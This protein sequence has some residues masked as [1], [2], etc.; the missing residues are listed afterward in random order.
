MM[1]LLLRILASW[2]P[3]AL[4]QTP[5]PTT[6]TTLATGSYGLVLAGLTADELTVEAAEFVSAFNDALKVSFSY[7]IRNVTAETSTSTYYYETDLVDIFL[8]AAFYAASATQA[9]VRANKFKNAVDLAVSVNENGTVPLENELSRC[10]D[11]MESALTN[12]YV[13]VSASADLLDAV[14]SF[15]F[16]TEVPTSAPTRMP[17]ISSLPTSVPTTPAPSSAL[18][19]SEPTSTFAPTGEIVRF[20]METGVVFESISS[21]Q[22]RVIDETVLIL[23]LVETVDIVENA[24]EVNVTS[25]DDLVSA[26]VD[27]LTPQRRLQSTT[28]NCVIKEDEATP[29]GGDEPLT[30]SNRSTGRRT[31]E[32]S[33]SLVVNFEVY[34]RA[35]GVDQAKAILAQFTKQLRA[36]VQTGDLETSIDS[37][38]NA[39]NK[40]TNISA[41]TVDV[42]SSVLYANCTEIRGFYYFPT[43]VP[44]IDISHASSD[45][46]ADISAN[47]H[48]NRRVNRRADSCSDPVSLVKS[49]A[50]SVSGPVNTPLYVSNVGTYIRPISVP[51]GGPVRASNGPSFAPSL[52]PSATSTVT[53][54]LPPI[55][56][57]ADAV[58]V[59]SSGFVLS[60]LGASDFGDE[61]EAIVQTAL[62]DVLGVVSDSSQIKNVEATDR[63]ISDRRSLEDA[64]GLIDVTFD[65]EFSSSSG[66]TQSDDLVDKVKDELTSAVNVS[67][68]T[69][70]V[71][72]RDRR[73]KC[74]DD[75]DAVADARAEHKS[76][77]AFAVVHNATDRQSDSSAKSLSDASTEQKSNH[78][79]THVSS[80]HHQT[81]LRSYNTTHTQAN[82]TQPNARADAVTVPT[83]F[84]AKSRDDPVPGCTDAGTNSAADF[85][86]D[87]FGHFPPNVVTQRAIC[88]GASDTCAD[89][90]FCP[91][92]NHTGILITR[93]LAVIRQTTL[94][95]T[96]ATSN[97]TVVPS[98]NPTSC[99]DLDLPSPPE[100][101][102]AAFTS[103]AAEVLVVFDSPTDQA[104]K[105]AGET[106]S[107]DEILTF[108]DATKADCYF[109]NA[110]WINAQVSNSVSFF[111]GGTVAL[112]SNTL[113][114][115]CPFEAASARCDCLEFADVSSVVAREPT[116]AVVPRVVLQGPALAS[117]CED[118]LVSAD[119][120]TGG[121]GRDMSFTWT[122]TVEDSESDTVLAVSTKRSRSAYFSLNSSQLQDFLAYGDEL[123][124]ALSASNYLGA[125]GNG[126]LAVTLVVDQVPSLI[127]IGGNELEIQRSDELEVVAEA[128][129]TN[130]DGRPNSERQVDFEWLLLLLFEGGASSSEVSMPS[131][132]SSSSSSSVAR[133]P[134][135]YKLDAFSLTT[136]SVYSL[137]A[138]ARDQMFPTLSNTAEVTI[139]VKSGD[140]L[141]VIDGGNER[142]TSLIS[143]FTLSAGTSRDEDV[144]PG[145]DADLAFLWSCE[146]ESGGDCAVNLTGT[147]TANLVVAG[148]T[149][150]EEGA[151][152]FSVVV[153]AADSR[154]TA[155]TS[156]VTIKDTK[157]TT[158]ILPIVEVASFAE[159]VLS[160]EKLTIAG[161]ISV[162]AGRADDAPTF[163]NSTWAVTRGELSSGA[164]LEAAAR[165][166]VTVSTK[167]AKSSL[168]ISRAHDLVLSPSTLVPGGTYTFA[169]EAD[170]N[171]EVGFASVSISVAAP[172]S[173]GSLDVAPQ[174]GVAFSDL[175]RLRAASWVGEDPLKYQFSTERGILRS[176]TLDPNLDDARLPLGFREP[177]LTV[178]VRVSDVYGAE[179]EL[180]TLV[181]IESNVVGITFND[182][183]AALA[184]AFARYSL[185]D[186][187]QIV[188]SAPETASANESRA[189]RSLVVSALAIAVE[190][191]VD[192][193]RELLI[194]ALAALLS[195]VSD[196]GGL[197]E[198]ASFEALDIV[199]DLAAAVARTGLGEGDSEAP[200]LTVQI[201]SSLLETEV[202]DE[203]IRQNETRSRQLTNEDGANASTLLLA[204]VDSVAQSQ[205]DT[206][207]DNEDSAGA[208]SDH[209]KTASARISAAYG[210]EARIITTDEMNASVTLSP[211]L[212]FGYA[213]SLTEFGIN[214]HGRENDGAEATSQ[215]LRFELDVSLSTSSNSQLVDE[216]TTV[217]LAIP[218]T[219]KSKDDT[220]IGRNSTTTTSLLNVTAACPCDFVGFV[221]A[222]CPDNT[223]HSLECDGTPS[224]IVFTCETT[225][226][227]CSTWD[228]SLKQWTIPDSC[229]SIENGK[230]TRCECRVDTTNGA[231]DYSTRDEIVDALARYT[232][233]FRT[234]PDLKKSRLV[235]AAFGVLV[236]FILLCVWI[237]RTLDQREW[238]VMESVLESVRGS[239]RR[240]V[241]RIDTEALHGFASEQAIIFLTEKSV[242][243]NIRLI[244]S[245]HPFLNFL[246][247]YSDSVSRTLRACKLGIELFIFFLSLGIE[248]ALEYP[249]TDCSKYNRRESCEREKSLGSRNRLCTWDV[250][251]GSFA[252]G[253]APDLDETAADVDESEVGE[254][255]SAREARIKEARQL[256]PHIAELVIKRQD[257]LHACMVIAR[258]RNDDAGRRAMKLLEE[259]EIR[260]LRKWEYVEQRAVW[261]SN[262]E[263]ITRR[264]MKAAIRLKE[265]LDAIASA[266]PP[267]DAI[268]LRTQKLIEHERVARL[269]G[270]EQRIY[271]RAK[272]RAVYQLEVPTTVPSL[273]AYVGAWVLVLVL[274]IGTICYLIL[275]A[276]ELGYGQ[277]KL[278]LVSVV[279][280]I[281]LYY[282][283]LKPVEILFFDAF[284]PSL[285]AGRMKKMHDPTVLSQ[286]PFKTPLPHSPLYYLCVMDPEVQKSKIGR[287]VMGH[288]HHQADV[289]IFDQLEEIYRDQTWKPL[290]GTRVFLWLVAYF[291]V[292]PAPLQEIFFEETLLIIPL[293]TKF[294]GTALAL[295]PALDST[296]QRRGNISE[297]VLM[298]GVV[299]FLVAIGITGRLIFST[300]NQSHRLT[301]NA[302]T[303]RLRRMTT[304]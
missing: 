203:I 176:S 5:A 15:S 120:S 101:A 167:H 304:A 58:T 280:T 283:I 112:R 160:N 299:I 73:N 165:T 148:G 200:E 35:G 14:F 137:R 55:P 89:D 272:D 185:D 286:F 235:L 41:A 20:A 206:L 184:S 238:H 243:H 97:P 242:R 60:G 159:P 111:P 108:E 7:E 158:T 125:T 198:E 67:G 74:C 162:A 139:T 144:A 220:S 216:P 24:S 127:I 54:T 49:F 190:N 6:A 204:T 222:R 36:A 155:T 274:F 282:L 53:P 30:A 138:T 1:L 149:F 28:T 70:R 95:P 266:A 116:D 8:D 269:T 129:A 52:C 277:S 210:E 250:C 102:D 84:R 64:A 98:A 21:A 290:I 31:E 208:A 239:R 197:E 17:T 150:E 50:C 141:A 11:P 113:K 122:V 199:S 193:D 45:A 2:L 209:V 96:A 287:Y 201:L 276:S 32:V 4:A 173:S 247:I 261:L 104:G 154:S 16:P 254:E 170:A 44:T 163:L 147:D 110:T 212:G 132:S 291:L 91:V 78:L 301:I 40:A 293:C 218:G 46:L 278:W 211:E 183:A 126:S 273:P 257:E 252:E 251:S 140:I 174:R 294:A 245:Q 271:A 263:T 34:E 157:T 153:L 181:H 270:P 161:D 192:D 12:A 93:G 249:S 48:P 85:L 202:F 244:M 92:N 217:A 109:I 94:M 43:S 75:R 151:Y 142:S 279:V 145:E 80:D 9:G 131:S 207:V 25:L 219:K 135:V 18:P 86:A 56:T 227:A 27:D 117:V 164:S 188:T 292:L 62:N 99:G 264:H 90:A 47:C 59:V 63:S 71:D 121:G 88:G 37:I 205:R 302:N 13:A 23:A 100:L 178:S 68:S 267:E 175:F 258:E 195:P 179:T 215:V 221:E 19:S 130:C 191:F 298:M 168:A 166:P 214:P 213:T 232:S 285:L 103:T 133:N 119:Q 241:G 231:T 177:N 79:P 240:P 295:P 22:F 289:D 224:E 253:D 105:M 39:T 38:A 189:V 69:S 234:T 51:V 143:T 284:L 237:G 87:V 152:A 182:T 172:P 260:L 300:L 268:A 236:A 128:F 171:G 246:T 146:T 66:S 124:V 10:C 187:C 233:T 275:I 256:A 259:L 107:C 230:E 169:L 3:Y 265:E 76:D 83:Y 123:T 194:Q 296:R 288:L 106:F 42:S 33:S 248:S 134:S 225:K 77:D 303:H 255:R 118:V 136:G 180:S 226:L 72:R 156:V 297:L 281:T 186:V 228:P 115:V 196:P 61:E 57:A 223:S 26:F 65:I 114:G 82:N 29:R 229:A 262:I 81:N